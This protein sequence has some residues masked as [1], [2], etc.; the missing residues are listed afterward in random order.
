MELINYSL[1]W[2]WEV[3]DKLLMERPDICQCERCRYDIAALAANRLKPNYV[4]GESG[5]VYTKMKMLSQQN[6]MDV[7][8]E[9]VKA[10]EQVSKN[11]H[12]PKD[13]V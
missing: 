6:Y 12:H 3:L 8:T 11:P 2:V 5:Y 10:I 13:S 9:V 7:V 4:V 1:K